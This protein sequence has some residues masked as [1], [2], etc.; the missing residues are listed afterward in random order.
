[1]KWTFLFS[2]IALF[3][4]GLYQFPSQAMYVGSPST[5]VIGVLAFVILFSTVLA[6]FLLPFG[7]KSLPATTVSIYMNLQPVVAATAAIF[8][9]QDYFSLDKPISA[10]LV[11]L[12]AYLVTRAPKEAKA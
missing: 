8:M 10:L 12:G 5:S 7:M 11:I 2:G 9:K 3:P 1:M 6:F 4:I